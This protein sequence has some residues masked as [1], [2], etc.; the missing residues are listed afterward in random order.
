MSNTI[1]QT[2]KGKRERLGMTL[3]EL[4]EKTRVKRQTL[5]L[6]ENNDFEALASPN[7]AEGIIMKYAK[8]VN[9]DASILIENHR[10][11]LPTPVEKHYGESIEQFKSANPPDYKTYNTESKQLVIWLSGFIILTLALWVAA[12]LLI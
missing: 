4:E 2:L 6:I 5:V 10:S 9:T 12:V 3:N 7:Y 8:V 1:G 11:E